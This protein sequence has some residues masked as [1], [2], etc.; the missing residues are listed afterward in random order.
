[1]TKGLITCPE[2]GWQH[3]ENANHNCEIS[4]SHEP[5][6]K[7]KTDINDVKLKNGN[8]ILFTESS[9]DKLI[10]ADDTYGCILKIIRDTLDTQPDTTDPVQ[11]NKWL[12][13]A[14]QEIEKLIEEELS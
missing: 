11:H 13:N 12:V 2:C 1:M 7:Q 3:G 10:S 14:L 8:A 4:R 6:A 5:G 9:M